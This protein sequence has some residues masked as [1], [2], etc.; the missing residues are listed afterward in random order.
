MKI[1]ELRTKILPSLRTPLME[2]PHLS[3]KLRGPRIFIKRD[4]LTGLTMGGNKTRALVSLMTDVKDMG[5]DIIIA[6]GP[7]QSNW[8]CSLTAMGR[9]LGMDVILFV[10]KGND[11]IQG[12]LLLDKLLGADIMFTGME[13][14][15]LSVLYK[16]MDTLAARLRGQGRRPDV[17]HYGPVTPLGIVGY[18]FLT[19]EIF[20]QLQEKGVTAQHLYLSSGSGSTQ[21]G[22][23]LGAKY[24]ESTLRIVGINPSRTTLRAEK[25]RTIADLANETARLLEMD[26][27]IEPEEIIVHDEYIGNGPEPT[28]KSFEAMKLIAQT[29]GIFLDPTYTGRAMAAL[30][31]QIRQAN[32][33]AGDTVVFYHSGGLPSIFAY[34]EEL[35][36]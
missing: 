9:K 19:E 18:V 26:C 3:A 33:G 24:F 13:I 27:I 23:L 36:T 15:E 22:L 35:S 20:E 1:Q 10:L 32:I 4:D 21:A 34:N 11:K 17:F 5:T 7:Q 6:V 28:K 16:Q 2:L 14:H 8:L 30:I 29:E 25:I 12:N 31:D